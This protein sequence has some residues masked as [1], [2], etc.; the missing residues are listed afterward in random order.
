[1]AAEVMATPGPATTIDCGTSP[2]AEIRIMIP[3]E[4][5]MPAAI[6]RV[7]S[8]NAKANATPR[9]VV[10]H[11]SRESRMTAMYVALIFV[12]HRKFALAGRKINRT[13]P[14]ISGLFV[15]V[16]HRFPGKAACQTK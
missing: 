7:L 2:N 8:R 12:G 11:E 10:T 4:N 14:S 5:P 16:N 13:N 15:L 1:M 3:V 9:Q 6:A